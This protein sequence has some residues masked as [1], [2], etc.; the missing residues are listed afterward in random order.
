M[1]NSRRSPEKKTR[2][3]PAVTL[4]ELEQRI[5]Y[6]AMMLAERQIDDGTV[7]AQV[8][9]QYIKVASSRERLEHE[10]LRNE[11]E[12]LKAKVEASNA[13]VRTE[14]LLQQALQ[15]FTTYSGRG[16][17]DEYEY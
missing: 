11:N 10:R 12:L 8:H 4:E 13:G 2:G 1:A 16:D 3:K 9:S 14:E 7:S 17:D 6:K 15:A 5:G